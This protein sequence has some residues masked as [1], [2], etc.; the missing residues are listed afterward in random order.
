MM[1]YHMVWM[2]LKPCEVAASHWPLPTEFRP[3]R[4]ISATIAEVNTVMAA[5]PLSSG[6]SLVKNRM[7]MMNSARGML[8][9]ISI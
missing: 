5:M 1:T 3:P 8:R 9:T 7:A 6:G 2:R 4:T